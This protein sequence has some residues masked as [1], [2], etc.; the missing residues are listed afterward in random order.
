MDDAIRFVPFD[1]AHPLPPSECDI[2]IMELAFALRLTPD[3][4][5]RPYL[6]GLW[7]EDRTG[8]IGLCHMASSWDEERCV[9]ADLLASICDAY[10]CVSLVPQACGLAVRNPLG[11]TTD[12]LETVSLVASAA[13]IV[14]VDTMVAHLAGALG[15]PAWLLLKADP[16]WRWSLGRT[17]PWYPSTRLYRQ[18]RAGDWAAV[19]AE[20]EADLEN[21]SG[22]AAQVECG[23]AHV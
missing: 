14:T 3:A 6:R 22:S 16:D 15:R 17:T 12:V 20:I 2:E 5:A 13:L 7:H 11:C 4:V 21:W 23:Q 19:V 1:P 8:G 18:P 10:D 9:P